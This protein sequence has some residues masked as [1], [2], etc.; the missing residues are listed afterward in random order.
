[1][2]EQ[3]KMHQVNGSGTYLLDLRVAVHVV[4]L[5]ELSPRSS[6]VKRNDGSYTVVCNRNRQ[7]CVSDREHLSTD[8][9][10]GF[11]LEAASPALTLVQFVGEVD[12]SQRGYVG[13]V[14]LPQ[15]V[16]EVSLQRFGEQDAAVV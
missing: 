15:P 2:A 1:M 12:A 10:K 5:V 7:R 6:S 9:A 13:E 3:L 16:E 14:A 11:V 4:G 8:Q